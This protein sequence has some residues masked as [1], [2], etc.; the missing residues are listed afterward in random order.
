MRIIG[1]IEARRVASAATD[2]DP[3]R[4]DLPVAWNRAHQEEDHDQ[5][6]EE[7]QESELPAPATVRLAA[8][9]GRE[10]NRCCGY[11]GFRRAA[12][13]R[14]GQ[15]GSRSRGRGSGHDSL[16]RWRCHR[17]GSGNGI[18]H[19]RLRLRA[20]GFDRSSRLSRGRTTSQLLQLCPGGADGRSSRDRGR[21]DG[22]LHR[23]LRQTGKPLVELCL[24]G[25][26]L[27]L[28][29]MPREEA[30]LRPTLPPPDYGPYFARGRSAMSL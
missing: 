10:A 30:H 24:V 19:G 15:D 27:W 26:I 18:Q 28:G 2:V 5:P 14:R 16:Y 29:G 20:R 17:R 11:H 6:G 8:R 1:E 21:G 13:G 23:R 12:D 7:Q 25:W 3:E 4:T 22:I 9:V